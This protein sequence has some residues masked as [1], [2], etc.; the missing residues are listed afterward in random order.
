M[1]KVVPDQLRVSDGWVRCGQCNEVFDANTHLQKKVGDQLIDT[2]PVKRKTLVE[3]T[4]PLAS[5][6]P[7]KAP[8]TPASIEI[9]PKAAILEAIA[10]V[11][12]VEPADVPIGLPVSSAPKEVSPSVELPPLTAPDEGRSAEVEHIRH[13]FL[14]VAGS[15]ARKNPRWLRFALSVSCVLLALVLLV[16]VLI[17][18]RD[19][20][21]ATEPST[22][23]FLESLCSVAGCRISPLRQI[24]SVV[25]DSSSFAKVRLDVFRLSFTLKNTAQVPIA[26]PALELTLTDMQDQ[27]VVRKVFHVADFGTQQSVMGPGSELTATLPMVVKLAGTAEKVSGYRLLSFYP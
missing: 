10:P 20:I 27:A 24:E 16:Q 6:D 2:P 19:R 4:T 7:P 25:I 21:V 15:S 18:E 5:E 1:F 9:S 3:V 8:E 22:K 12:H 11:P 23:R 17:Q 26:I 14:Q 13:T